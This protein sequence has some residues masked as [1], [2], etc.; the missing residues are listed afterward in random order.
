[1]VWD[2]RRQREKRLDMF[3]RGLTARLISA[4]AFGLLVSSAYRRVGRSGMIEAVHEAWPF[5]ATSAG[6]RET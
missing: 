1:M 4:R 3:G 5:E 6:M 2:C